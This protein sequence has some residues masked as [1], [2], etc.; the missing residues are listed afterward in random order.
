MNRFTGFV[1][2]PVLALT[3]AIFTAGCHKDGAALTAANDQSGTQDQ[4][5]DPAAANLAPSD[6]QQA[7]APS[8]SGAYS[9][10]SPDQYTDDPG[11]GTQ[12]VAYASQPP[13]PLPDYEQPPAPGDGYLWT[14]GYWG[15]SS[16]GYYWVPG[17]WV[18]APY[19]GALWTPGY[20]GYSHNRYG[21]YRGYWGPHIGFYGGVNYGFGYVGF[22]YSGGYW[23][24]GHFNYNRAV[25]NV[26]ISVVHAVYDHPVMRNTSGSVRVSF[27]G[28]QGGLQVRAR[29]AELAARR[30]TH[31]APMSAQVQIEH[32]ASTNRAQ[33][34]HGA[35]GHPASLAVSR[36][37]AADR[38]VRVPP[39]MPEHNPAQPPVR[40]G[41]PI[42]QAAPQA[43]PQRQS[44]PERTVAGPQQQRQVAP[45]PQQHQAAPQQQRQ[46]PPQQQRQ[47]A[48]PQQ[49]RQ[50][51]PPPQRQAPPAPHQAAPQ[52]QRQAAPQPQH[53]AA[54]PQ[55]KQAA[56]QQHHPAPAAEEK[57][58]EHGKM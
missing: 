23:G 16:D 29:P 33:F 18:Q 30:E 42:R 3:I 51:A 56:P 6:G 17:A 53:H 9:S 26:N 4:G 40:S 32:V 11:Y 36:P 15:Y 43:T 31:S 39:A 34:V 54:A 35:G 25:N 14:P 49:Q 21:F 5:S 24:G 48:P 52:P 2:L 45:P 12:P 47:A 1:L 46:A 22:G 37:L 7:S 44:V 10:A 38:N 41:E 19:Q 55:Q 58:P 13:P 57:K 28:G 50:A 27:N 8:E 20:W